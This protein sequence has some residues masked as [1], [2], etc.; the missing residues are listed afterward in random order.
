M[1]LPTIFRLPKYHV[2]NYKPRYWNPKKEEFEA[3]VER[4][5]REAG[6]GKVIDEKGNYVPNIKGRMRAYMS[7]PF[8]AGRRKETQNA[9]FRFLVI[10]AILA[11]IAY[12]LVFM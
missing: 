12:Y 2:F 5:K 7:S 4:A 8:Q 9:N 1:N 10:L 6:A 3:R 11:F